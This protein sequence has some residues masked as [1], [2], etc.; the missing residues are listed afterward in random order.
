MCRSDNI[1]LNGCADGLY[2]AL[3]TDGG[4]DMYRSA[5]YVVILLWRKD[6]DLRDAV[7]CMDIIIFRWSHSRA[8]RTPIC[9]RCPCLN[10]TFPAAELRILFWMLRC[11]SV[12]ILFI[13]IIE[14]VV[15]NAICFFYNL[16]RWCVFRCEL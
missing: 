8:G 14:N 12:W 10:R 15:C 6:E 9:F 3:R 2:G 13:H 7:F 1:S 11:W 16:F 5:V 4:G